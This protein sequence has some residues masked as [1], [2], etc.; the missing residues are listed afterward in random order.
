VADHQPPKPKKGGQMKLSNL[1]ITQTADQ[2]LAISSLLENLACMPKN[3]NTDFAY[4]L[5]QLSFDVFRLANELRSRYEIL[6]G[7]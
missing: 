2:L 4:Y 5:D 3:Y 1:N 6:G 7:F